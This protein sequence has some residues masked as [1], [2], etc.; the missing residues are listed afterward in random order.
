MCGPEAVKTV[1]LRSLD[2]HTWY[3]I[4][5]MPDSSW[6]NQMNETDAQKFAVT[7]RKIAGGYALSNII[8]SESDLDQAIAQFEHQI[9]K[10]VDLNHPIRLDEWFTYFA[11]DAV[12]QLTFSQ[13]FGFL[14]HGKDVGNCIATSHILVGYPT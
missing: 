5:A 8:K 6:P 11:F 7:Q 4:F 13:A 2:K 10:S 14:E 1:L 9:N 3:K 12:G